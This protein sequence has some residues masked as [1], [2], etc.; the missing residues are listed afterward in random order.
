MAHCKQAL[1]RIRQSEKRRLR[2]KSTRAEIKTI[3]KK[4]TD[5]VGRKDGAEARTLLQLV[6][7]RIDKAKKVHIFHANAANRHKSKL[8][9][10]VNQSTGPSAAAAN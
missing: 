1:K 9:L 8:A 4:L 5:A 2:G 7:S 6:I 3:T 10:L